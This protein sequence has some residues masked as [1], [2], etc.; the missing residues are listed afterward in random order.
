M[1]YI[2]FEINGQPVLRYVNLSIL[3]SPKFSSVK[4]YDLLFKIDLVRHVEIRENRYDNLLIGQCSEIGLLN[5]V[6]E[7]NFELNNYKDPHIRLFTKPDLDYFTPR[8]N[9]GSITTFSTKPTSNQ[10]ERLYDLTKEERI[11]LK[12]N[13]R[14]YG[15]VIVNNAD[16]IVFIDYFNRT[17]IKDALSDIL[18]KLR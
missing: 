13:L 12:W 4:E 7:I 14:G 5:T 16:H 10:I 15:S 1:E 9:L 18:N 8:L 3:L 2:N 11:F 6:L 17:D